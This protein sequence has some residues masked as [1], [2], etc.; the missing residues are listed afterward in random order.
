[1]EI[2]DIMIDDAFKKLTRYKYYKAKYAESEKAKDVEEPEEQNE[3]VVRS[4]RGKGYMRSGDY[5]ANVPKMF[6]KDVVLRKTRSLTAAEE[7][8][9]VKL[10]K[11]ISIDEQRTHQRRRS[12]LTIDRQID[13]DLADTYAEWGQKLKGPAVDDPA[14]QSL[15]DL[16]KGSKSSRLESLRQKKQAVAGEGSNTSEESDNG[17]DDANDSDMDLS[18]DNPNEDDDIAGFGVFMYNKSTETP[19]STYFSLTIASSSLDFIQN[20]LDETLVNELTDLMSNTVYTDAHTT[21]VVHNPKGNP[22][23]RSFLS[24]ASE[25]PFG[26]QISLFTK[27]STSTDDL[28]D[29][30]LKLKLLN[31]IY[32]SKSNTTHLTNQ[33][34]YDTIYESVC[35]DH[36]T[37]NDQDAE[38][39]FHKRSHD[40]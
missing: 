38:P 29:M 40:N 5:K 19:K 20:L 1:M 2:P 22:E 21:S 18:D 32:E 23:V 24:G 33:K 8:I 35:L 3:S 6:K 12:Q 28:S 17:T 13:N 11:S 27:P 34:L 25:V 37:L 10:V 4:G 9:A 36:D 39:S 15:L 14:L 30:D 16:Q 7:T 31:R 26:I